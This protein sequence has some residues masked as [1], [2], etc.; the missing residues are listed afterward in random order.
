MATRMAHPNHGF[1]HAY[2]NNDIAYLEKLGWSVEAEKKV[3]YRITIDHDVEH[4]PEP[5]SLLMNEEDEEFLLKELYFVT[6]GKK[7]HHMA[8][9]ETIRK[10]INDHGK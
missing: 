10:A 9:L 1:T 2:N 4:E 6:F 5:D 3:E 8:K 7:P